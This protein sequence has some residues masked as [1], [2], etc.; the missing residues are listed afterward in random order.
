MEL[1]SKTFCQRRDSN[2]GSVALEATATTTEALIITLVDTLGQGSQQL[3]SSL[4]L[5]NQG[6]L[7]QEKS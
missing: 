5:Q 4:W 7:N 2:G 3:K 6:E 1:Q